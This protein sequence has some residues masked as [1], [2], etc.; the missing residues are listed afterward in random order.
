M[1]DSRTLHYYKSG[2]Y[3]RALARTALYG[4]GVLLALGILTVLWLVVAM[5][6]VSPGLM[7][8][9]QMMCQI[10]WGY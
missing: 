4:S 6:V 3:I 8:L 2:Q 7:A 10:T 9:M 1:N 5:F